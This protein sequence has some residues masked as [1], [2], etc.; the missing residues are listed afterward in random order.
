MD[1]A[2]DRREGS[3][4]EDRDPVRSASWR[5]RF[6]AYSVL[7]FVLGFLGIVAGSAVVVFT[8]RELVFSS[9]AAA[10]V[11]ATAFIVAVSVAMTLLMFSLHRE[12][13]V[14]ISGRGRLEPSGSPLAGRAEFLGPISV[15][16][17][18][19][20]A[21]AP[22]LLSSLSL[23]QANLRFSAALVLMEA[24]SVPLLVLWAVLAVLA[25]R[26]RE[27]LGSVRTG[28]R[29]LRSP[30][31]SQRGL[32]A[33]PALTVLAV[34]LAWIALT[35]LASPA[36]LI[37]GRFMDWSSAPTHPVPPA[38]SRVRIDGLVVEYDFAQDGT[39]PVSLVLSDSSANAASWEGVLT[40]P[41]DP[42]IPSFQT[43]TRN[44]TV[45]FDASASIDLDGSV[46]LWTWTFGDGTSDPGIQVS[47]TYPWSG[48]YNASL[49]VE[50]DRGAA[51]TIASAVRVSGPEHPPFARARV[52]LVGLT[53]TG[54]GSG[55]Y[56]PDGQIANY[57]WAWGDGA[58]GYGVLATH[59]YASAGNFT[60]VLQV[61][62]GSGLTS[63][64]SVPADVPNL[65]PTPDFSYVVSG[66]FVA[67]D[68]T[69]SVD[70]DGSLR[71]FSWSFGDGALG[72]GP[73][74]GHPYPASGTYA[75]VLFV[76]D[77]RGASSSLLRSVKV[78][79]FTETPPPV[80][81][82]NVNASGLLVVVDAEGSFDPG[83]SV[84]S[85]FWAFG[86]D[87]TA[88]GIRVE[89]LYET[90]GTY[91]LNLKVVAAD[92]RSSQVTR[93]LDLGENAS[94]LD[95]PTPVVRIRVSGRAVTLDASASTDAGGGELHARWSIR[96][97]R[98]DLQIAEVK[99]IADADQ[100]FLYLRV[101]GPPATPSGRFQIW[102]SVGSAD[103]YVRDG[104]SY[105]YQIGLD[106]R[107]PRRATVLRYAG[108]SLGVDDWRT[109]ASVPVA[110]N[111]LEWEVGIGRSILL[112]PPA[113]TITVE[114]VLAGS[115]FV[116]VPPIN[117]PPGT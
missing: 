51:A 2:D 22:S 112:K 63:A 50:D 8:I 74:V 33:I 79:P 19:S 58:V 116:S 45:T 5:I 55:S 49:R 64:V 40:V 69:S 60:V 52:R 70:A 103:G 99:A 81:V 57:T 117:L 77:D 41:N 30:E 32:P 96:D 111:G 89:H 36:I 16:L 13:F 29:D 91:G 67:F 24:L 72:Q 6:R 101:G 34:L 108:G 31:V 9:T 44:L 37:D 25:F 21:S 3:G 100:V 84:L 35:P 43:T 76:E 107:S 47:H 27:S 54:D 7:L 1:R 104:L 88:Q 56:D 85:F 62:D 102:L 66:P 28:R 83:G 26:R 38:D 61:R 97:R 53:A 68:A 15:A 106:P 113:V 73:L 105:E 18:L 10:I 46:V 109:I 82:L 94:D 59:T 87:S 75:V 17:A 90:P 12:G 71:A 4:R 48:D 98:S 92:G 20:M 11:F 39:Y 23:S 78:P 93:S 14:G 110:T 65:P 86:D 42:P 95:P 115:V 80:P 114:S